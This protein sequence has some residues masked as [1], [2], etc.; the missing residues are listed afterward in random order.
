MSDAHLSARSIADDQPP[1]DGS[2]PIDLTTEPI[3]LTH[4]GVDDD[5]ARPPR[6]RRWKIAMGA[7]L[8]V[9]LAGAAVFGTFGW[10]VAEQK[11]TTLTVRPE[12]AGLRE[13]DSERA[14]STADYLRSGFAA[15]IELDR[16]FGAVYQDPA[17]DKKSVLVFGGTTLLWQ[18]ERE[19]DTLFGTMTDETGAVEG[20]RDVPAGPLGGVM[21]C[22]T[23]SGEG[24][25]FAVCGWA[26]H[27]SVVMGMFPGRPVDTAAGLFRDIREGI[28][29]RS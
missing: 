21:K 14:R 26:D 23:T 1:S 19:L 12:V 6:S 8:A 20:L 22:G 17:D 5:E 29:T 3:R 4:P 24:G 27:G 11:D 10:R 7:G 16:S 9:G 2:T 15:S 28:Q 18:P 25:D 13:D